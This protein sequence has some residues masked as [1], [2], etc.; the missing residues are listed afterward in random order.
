MT[1]SDCSALGP[2]GVCTAGLCRRPLL[3]TTTDG[4]VL[5][6]ADRTAEMK[7][8]L[9]PVVASADRS[10]MTDADCV[11]ATLWNSCYGTG[12]NWVAVSSSGAASIAAELATLQSEDCDAAFR[13]GCAAAR[14]FSCPTGSPIACISGV[15]QGGDP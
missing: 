2:T 4:R 14:G 9:E 8:K 5:T 3:V 12:C 7:A 1:D 6:C 10:C 11:Q 13:A 15:C